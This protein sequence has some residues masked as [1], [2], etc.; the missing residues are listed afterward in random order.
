[1]P[2][3]LLYE[4]NTRCWLRELADQHGRDIT[5][6]TVPDDELAR[7]RQLGFTHIWLMG[8][9]TTGPLARALALSHPDLRK[10]YDEVLPGW[11]EQDVDG[12]PY[13]IAGYRV[14]RELGGEAG[15]DHAQHR[16]GRLLAPG[17]DRAHELLEEERVALGPLEQ[18][19]HDLVGER[20][21]RL[22]H[23]L[24]ARARG[25][26]WKAPRPR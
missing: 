6:A 17:R 21:E 24:G 8:V 22:A 5:L 12:S 11:R 14:A 23:E 26:R 18:A 20:P 7:W 3:P 4:I 25:Q 13:A 19:P 1:M 9:W 2:Q 15:L 16:V 10:A